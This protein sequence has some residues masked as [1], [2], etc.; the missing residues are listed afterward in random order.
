MVINYHNQEKVSHMNSGGV[1]R[2]CGA[3]MESKEK[4]TAYA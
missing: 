3:V 2:G 1:A 4:T